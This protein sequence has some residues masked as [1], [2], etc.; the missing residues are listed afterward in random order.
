M[1]TH[2]PFFIFYLLILVAYLLYSSLLHT[3]LNCIAFCTKYIDDLKSVSVSVFVKWYQTRA[4]VQQTSLT[5]TPY[6]LPSPPPTENLSLDSLCTKKILL[7]FTESFHS[8]SLIHTFFPLLSK[9]QTTWHGGTV[10]VGYGLCIHDTYVYILCWLMRMIWWPIRN[11][12]LVCIQTKTWAFFSWGSGW[13][14]K[15]IGI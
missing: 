3:K 14:E 6:T 7:R 11:L 5:T 13:T 4:P 10:V 9:C 12:L 15:Q 1:S 2:S 8:F